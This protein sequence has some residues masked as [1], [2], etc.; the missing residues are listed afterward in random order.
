MGLPPRGARPAK[1]PAAVLRKASTKR[2]ALAAGL[3][4]YLRDWR[5]FL[6]REHLAAA[7]FAGLQVDVVRAAQLAGLLVL[8]VG[9][10]R[11]AHRGTGGNRASCARF[12]VSG[13]AS[14][15]PGWNGLTKRR[16]EGGGLSGADIEASGAVWP[17]VPALIQD[18][19]RVRLAGR[20]PRRDAAGDAARAAT[21]IGRIAG[22]RRGQDRGEPRRLRA[23]R[24]LP[25]GHRNS[26]VRPPPRRRPLHPIRRCSG[27]S[28]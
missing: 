19:G 21:R 14:V 24:A 4:V 8:D 23:R 26:A 17:A 6:R 27:R 15:A 5:L 3:R 1:Q 18:A 11:R 9:R 22:R 10:L 7:I 28:P 12:F 20:H 25:P 13:Q 16:L 2:P